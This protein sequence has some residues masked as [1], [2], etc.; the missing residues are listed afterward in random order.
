MPA[1]SARSSCVNA[2]RTRRHPDSFQCLASTEPQIEGDYWTVR[3]YYSA[4]GLGVMKTKLTTKC[5]I[6]G[7][8]VVKMQ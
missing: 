7:G 8:D 6:Q 1:A 4:S 3:I 2:R 5:W